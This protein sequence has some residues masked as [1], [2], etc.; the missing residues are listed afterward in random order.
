MIPHCNKNVIPS[1]KIPGAPPPGRKDQEVSFI[2]FHSVLA[3]P[4]LLDNIYSFLYKVFCFENNLR[5][6]HHNMIARYK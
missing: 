5:N 3:Q 2:R 1:P 4:V 6:P